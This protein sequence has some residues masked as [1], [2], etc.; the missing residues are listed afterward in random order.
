MKTLTFENGDKMPA[1]GLGT[2]KSAPGDVKTAVLEAIKT[3]YRHIDCAFV[4]GNENEVGEAILEAIQSGLVTREELWI[5]SKLW[6]SYHKKEDVEAGLIASLDA[7]NLDYLDLYLIHWPVAMKSRIL[8]PQSGA[9]FIALD[10]IP[11]S[12]TWL[13]MIELRKKGT[14]R[15]IGVSNFSISKIEEIT[16]QTG[17]KPEMNQFERHVHLQQQEL[18]SYCRENGIFVTCYAPLGSGDRPARVRRDNEPSVMQNRIVLDLA[19]KNN[20]SPAQLLIAW[21]LAKDLSVIPKSTNPE[22]ILQNFMSKDITLPQEDI[23][24]LDRLDL[25]HRY[26]DGQF[27]AQEG[28]PYTIESLWA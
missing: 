20:I 1:L 19:A 27:W 17:I 23:N 24:T 2:W 4:Y 5:T 18:I 14:A 13:E 26:I 11:L 12:E 21:T 8:L 9:D 28:S 25:G 22:R 10:Q 6:N 3:G 16:A 15:H 7:L